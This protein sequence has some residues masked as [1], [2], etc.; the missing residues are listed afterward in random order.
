MVESH[1][2][3]H[4]HVVHACVHTAQVRVEYG[5]VQVLGP[6]AWIIKVL[7]LVSHC[8]LIIILAR[9]M[10]TSAL[11]SLS[12]SPCIRSDPRQWRRRDEAVSITLLKQRRRGVCARA[13]V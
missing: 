12:V 1:K 4:A 7:N 5:V 6:L 2:A 9:T 10:L 11:L 13:Y 8:G 3:R